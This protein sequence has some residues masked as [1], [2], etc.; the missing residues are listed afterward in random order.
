MKSVSPTDEN[1][2]HQVAVY[3]SITV[4]L[5]VL[6]KIVEHLGTKLGYRFLPTKN[7]KD[8]E[9]VSEKA[10]RKVGESLW[11]FMFYSFAL[12][13]GYIVV[14]GKGFYRD[15]K[16][17]WGQVLKDEQNGGNTLEWHM[18]PIPADLKFYYFLEVSFYTAATVVHVTKT[19]AASQN[20]DFWVML[21]H[22]VVTI[23]LIITS[24]SL[25]VYRVGVV[26]MLLHDWCDPFLE[27]AK[28]LK[29]FRFMDSSLAMFITFG[30]VFHVT[31][32]YMYPSYVILSAITETL[33]L[34]TITPLYLYYYYFA[35]GLLFVILILNGVWSA[36][37][38]KGF[39]KV[40]FQGGE[41]HDSRS[42][43]EDE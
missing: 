26:V 35:I 1:L 29:Y 25:N 11:R 32:L 34:I 4:T 40:L 31:R 3:A 39:A 10:A 5:L 41:A 23:S 27:T 20:K 8:K 9:V 22:H 24:Y 28:L 12:V 37:I 30:V 19:S 43:D 38:L 21:I 2:G 16:Q 7:V 6:Q 42:D 15:S 14:S 13:Y 33:E 36:F 18:P 17:L